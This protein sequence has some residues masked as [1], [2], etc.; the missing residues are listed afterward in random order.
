[1]GIDIYMKW[2]DAGKADADAQS[3]GFSVT[4]GHVGYLREAYHGGPYVTRHLVAEAFSDEAH[5]LYDQ[6]GV[7]IPA[8][9][10]RTRLD[11]AVLLSLIRDATV[12]G[13]DKEPGHINIEDMDDSLFT[14]EG[15]KAPDFLIAVF[16]E[17]KAMKEQGAFDGVIPAQAVHVFDAWKKG[18]SLPDFAQTFVDFVELAEKKEAAT[19]E[20]V[21]VLASY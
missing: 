17:I 12:Y 10:M 14:G 20:P 3:T 5:D 9:M 16:G 19:G 18:N 7:Q 8:S 6:G 15:G 4:H 11:T 21:R 13:G 2:K 1:M